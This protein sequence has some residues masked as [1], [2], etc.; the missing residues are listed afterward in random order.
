MGYPYEIRNRQRIAVMVDELAEDFT[1]DLKSQLQRV[2]ERIRLLVQ[3][4]AFVWDS[5]LEHS[6]WRSL[7][8]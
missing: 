4:T 3:T 6:I 8:C 5:Q 7:R 1:P 2:D